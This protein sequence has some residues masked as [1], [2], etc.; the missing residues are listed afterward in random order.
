MSVT[1]PPTGT[2]PELPVGPPS[3]PHP[4]PSGATRCRSGSPSCSSSSLPADYEVVSESPGKTGGAHSARKSAAGDVDTDAMQD[5]IETDL[6][7]KTAYAATLA[8]PGPTVR[9]ETKALR[10]A[11]KSAETLEAETDNTPSAARR[12]LILRAV[13]GTADKTAPDPLTVKKG[14]DP[15]AAFT[16]ALPAGTTPGDRLGD[17]QERQVWQTAYGKAAADAA[18]ARRPGG[19]KSAACRTS[20]GGSGP[21]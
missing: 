17:A 6:E 2:G 11:L 12:V 7:A 20:A 8:Q 14:L 9:P 15:L 4:S 21:P 16:T 10:Q 3:P 13:L 18:S 19:C 5:L 1:P